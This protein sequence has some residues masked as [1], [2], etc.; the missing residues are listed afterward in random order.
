MVIDEP[1]RSGATPKAAVKPASETHANQPDAIIVGKILAKYA[2][3]GIAPNVTPTTDVP[4][5]IN[6]V[7]SQQETDLA[8]IRRLAERNG[9]V[10]YIEPL[11][12]GTS[13]AYWGL[14]HGSTRASLGCTDRIG[15]GRNSY[16]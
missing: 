12:P 9:F 7:P 14:V 16:P 4:I 5:E 3:Y 2:Q 11:F 15:P 8:Y 13:Q 1:K 6:R 10:F